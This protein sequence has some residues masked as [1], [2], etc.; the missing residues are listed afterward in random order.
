MRAQRGAQ[1]IISVRTL[2]TQSRMA[3]L[4]ASFSVWMPVDAAHLG[5]QQPHAE[6]VERLPL[7]V[8]RAHVDD[9]VEA[10]AGA[11][12][13]GG[14][15]VLSRAGFSDDAALAHAPRQQDLAQGVVDLVRAGV[16]EIFALQ[17]NSR[18]AGVFA[19][20]LGIVQGRGAATELGEQA[21]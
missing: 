9:A 16:A 7:H 8:L 21:A 4:M 12:R 17:K 20:P 2:V 18:A 3:S 19:E 1:Q 11:N 14:D 6:D 10:E 5:A 13:G 15:A